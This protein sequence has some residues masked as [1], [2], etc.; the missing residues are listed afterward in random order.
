MSTLM[1]PPAL[2]M[3]EKKAKGASRQKREKAPIKSGERPETPARYAVGTTIGAAAAAENGEGSSNVYHVAAFHGTMDTFINAPRTEETLRLVNAKDSLGRTPLI[4]AVKKGFTHCVDAMVNVGAIINMEDETT[5]FTPLMLAASLGHLAMVATIIRRGGDMHECCLDGPYKGMTPGQLAEGGKHFQVMNLLTNC[6]HAMVEDGRDGVILECTQLLSG[7]VPPP[8]PGLVPKDAVEAI[9]D[10]KDGGLKN[11]FGFG[12]KKKKDE[13]AENSSVLAVVPRPKSVPSGSVVA[14]PPVHAPNVEVLKEINAMRRL[15]RKEKAAEEEQDLEEQALQVRH[16]RQTLQTRLCSSFVAGGH[17]LGLDC[18]HLGSS[19]L[20]SSRSLSGPSAASLRWHRPGEWLQHLPH[21]HSAVF[22]CWLATS[23]RVAG[24]QQ[25]LATSPGLRSDLGV[26]WQRGAGGAAGGG[27]G[28]RG[29]VSPGDPGGRRG[30]AGLPAEGAGRGERAGGAVCGGDG[31]REGEVCGCKGALRRM[32]AD[33]RPAGEG[34]SRHDCPGGD[35]DPRFNCDFASHACDACVAC[36][37]VRLH[38]CISI[39]CNK[40]NAN[41]VFV[42]QATAVDLH[43]SVTAWR[44][45]ENDQQQAERARA[46]KALDTANAK[47]PAMKEK[48]AEMKLQL[49]AQKEEVR[50]EKAAVA[51]EVNRREY[52]ATKIQSMFRGKKE[53]RQRRRLASASSD[54]P[55]TAG[56]AMWASEE[57]L[58]RIEVMRGVATWLPADRKGG[59]EGKEGGKKKGGKGKKPK[60]KSADQLAQE[61]EQVLHQRP[62]APFLH[63]SSLLQLA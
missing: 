11:L 41:C 33:N 59:G 50:R 25:V 36:N 58:A 4:L 27:E 51:A 38:R 55:S 49:A 40:L 52:A 17:Q 5:G 56:A 14:L 47:L 13:E 7:E 53:R 29:R 43:K 28:L 63:W 60:E 34:A 23:V 30:G 57:E 32:R 54:Q 48:V 24:W 61:K 10:K 15:I 1:L 9:E 37:F 35:S 21:E 46:D 3:P 18:A 42:F 31:G 16:T 44:K 22:G 8:P 6:G 45:K 19:A 12:S 2:P 62:T 26:L 20:C 39:L